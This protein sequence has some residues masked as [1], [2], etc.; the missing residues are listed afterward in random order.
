MLVC[1]INSQPS[2]EDHILEKKIRRAFFDIR[3][4]MHLTRKCEQSVAESLCIYSKSGLI[5]ITYRINI[6]YDRSLSRCVDVVIIKA[7]EKSM[8]IITSSRSLSTLQ[9]HRNHRE[10]LDMN[11]NHRNTRQFRSLS[12]TRQRNI[13]VT[14]R[15][16]TTITIIAAGK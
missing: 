8:W 6:A 13:F 9:V 3:Y 12:W 2:H 11:R 4:R 15:L 10:V 14:T 1:P 16:A 7:T 5:D